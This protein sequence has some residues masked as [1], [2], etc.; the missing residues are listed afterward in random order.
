MDIMEIMRARH[1]VRRYLDKPIEEEKRVKI[2]AEAEAVSR[3][4]GLI[5]TP[6]F[7]E[8]KAFAGMMARYGSFK[9][10]QNYIVAIGEKDDDEAIGYFGERLVLFLQSI[11]INSCWVALT[12]SKSKVSVNIPQGKKIHVVIAMGYGDGEGAAHKNAPKEKLCRVKGISEPKWFEVA[13]EA[14]MLAPTALN[15]QKFCI[16]LEEDGTVSAKALVA[17]YAEMD[18]GIVKYHFELGAAYAG[19]SFRF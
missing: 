10:C 6:V 17:P 8:P 13:M 7:D 9:G 14:A 1:S 16:T 19:H 18:L 11:G 4:S 2:N 5:F 12:Y 3:E 15:H